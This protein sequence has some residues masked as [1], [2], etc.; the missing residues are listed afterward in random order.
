[1]RSGSD[2]GGS[3]EARGLGNRPKWM[4]WRILETEPVGP[5]GVGTEMTVMRL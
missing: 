1:M 3:G 4:E 5:S 2:S